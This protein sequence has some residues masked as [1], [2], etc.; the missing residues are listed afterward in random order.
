M[1]KLRK[2]LGDINALS[3][4]ALMNLIDM[5]SKG[6]IRKWC[7]D[8]ADYKIFPLFEK[9]CPGDCRPR[10][11]IDAARDYLAGKV[12]FPAV[13]DIILNGCHA[14]ARE[15]IVTLLHRL[16]HGLSV[17]ARQSFIH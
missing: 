6:T 14:S 2:T 11:A 4:I 8:Y 9:H 13:K 15:L 12:K 5:Q 3:V 16:Q 1:K 10:K 17:K 7:L